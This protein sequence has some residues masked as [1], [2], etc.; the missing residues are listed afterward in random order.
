[1]SLGSDRIFQAL[2]EVAG[3]F[4]DYPEVF[5]ISVHCLD[6]AGF[7]DDSPDNVPVKHQDNVLHSVLSS[8]LHRDANRVASLKQK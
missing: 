3:F 8:D 7:R 2:L 5:R 6:I 4:W 1:M